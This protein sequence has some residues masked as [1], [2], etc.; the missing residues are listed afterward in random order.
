MWKDRLIPVRIIA[1][2]IVN[3]NLSSSPS[4]SPTITIHHHHHQEWCWEEHKCGWIAWL[5]LEWLSA[6]HPHGSTNHPIRKVWVKVLKIRMRKKHLFFFVK[7][8][9]TQL[10]KE[11]WPIIIILIDL[12][13]EYNLSLSQGAPFIILSKNIFRVDLRASSL[14]TAGAPILAEIRVPVNVAQQ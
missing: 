9:S 13:V 2:S 5:Q 1:S 4:T 10:I 6:A 7:K 8:E 3:D 11:C 12:V 14:D